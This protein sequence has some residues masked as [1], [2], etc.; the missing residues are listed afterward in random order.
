MR[1]RPAPASDTSRNKIRNSPDSR[2]S[3]KGC[4]V[5]L[6]REVEPFARTRSP[7]YVTAWP[8]AVASPHRGRDLEVADPFASHAQDIHAGFTGRAVPVL[9]CPSVNVDDFAV[10]GY[11]CCCRC[12][13]IEQELLNWAAKVG[14]FQ[15]SVVAPSAAA[16]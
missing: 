2:A 7:V 13:T 12:V 11:N 5:K 15:R 8:W 6:S 14:P 4:T 9:T 16:R 10:L 1:C 3:V